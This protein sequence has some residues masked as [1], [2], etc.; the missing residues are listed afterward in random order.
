M[1]T[2]SGERG[3]T[4]LSRLNVGR[5]AISSVF[6]MLMS[7]IGCGSSS[8][9]RPSVVGVWSLDSFG[10]TQPFAMPPAD[11][12]SELSIWLKEDDSLLTGAYNGLHGRYR[13]VD[14]AFSSSE[15]TATAFL[16]SSLE[17][18]SGE[19]AERLAKADRYRVEGRL[20]TLSSKRG[21]LVLTNRLPDL[22]QTSWV[23]N[24]IRDTRSVGRGTTPASEG[25][26][27]TLTFQSS[28]VVHV[29][30]NCNTLNELSYHLDNRNPMAGSTGTHSGA[31]WDGSFRMSPPS[32]MPHGD[33]CAT[34]DPVFDQEFLDLLM[35]ARTYAVVRGELILRSAA[36]DPQREL[37]F[38][39]RTFQ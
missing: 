30:N 19:F 28:S 15:L 24:R 23:L 31:K 36:D 8:D 11:S 27:H 12:A 14:G 20:L 34:G 37:V 10:E 17:P 25:V 18:Q 7:A 9:G 29:L 5:L 33:T 3:S 35:R 26:G 32:T 6:A 22:A 2:D 38:K 39:A 16:N 13:V 1:P 4:A 21:E